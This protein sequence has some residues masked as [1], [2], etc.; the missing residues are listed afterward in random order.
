MDTFQS[1]TSAALPVYSPLY[2]SEE[3]DIFVYFLRSESKYP[4]VRV[5]M[6]A[7]HVKKTSEEKLFSGGYVILYVKKVWHYENYYLRTCYASGE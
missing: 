2:G 1:T 4:C 7:M 6:S 5:I 3:R